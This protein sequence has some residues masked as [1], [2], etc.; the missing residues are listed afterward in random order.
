M[1]T[2]KMSQFLM[3][4]KGDSSGTGYKKYRNLTMAYEQRTR[5]MNKCVKAA[6]ALGYNTGVRVGTVYKEWPVMVIEL[7]YKKNERTGYHEVAWHVSREDYKATGRIYYKEW[8]GS[9][10]VEK[11]RRVMEYVRVYAA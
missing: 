8:D 2:E 6:H 4:L 1:E 7:P 9:D 11:Y 5:L 10:T 3:A